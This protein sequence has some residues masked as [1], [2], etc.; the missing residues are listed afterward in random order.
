ILYVACTRAADYLILSSSISDFAKPD[1]DWMQLVAG[2]FELTTGAVRGALPPGYDMPRVGVV[3]EEPA[4]DFRPIGRTR[5]A[6][7]QGI[8]AAARVEAEAGGGNV[9]RDVWPVPVD[10]TARRRYSVSRLSGKIFRFD[11]SQ[12]AFTREL[13]PSVAEKVDPLELGTL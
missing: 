5:G 4:V 11:P 2:R 6:D 8:A 7:L 12:A 3:F 9:P 10:T 13:L 1:S